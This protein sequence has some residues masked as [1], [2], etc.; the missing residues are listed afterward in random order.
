MSAFAVLIRFLAALLFIG[1]VAYRFFH[2][3]RAAEDE[4]RRA[5]IAKENTVTLGE[6]GESGS[7]VLGE[8]L[9]R[10]REA[11]ARRLAKG[12]SGPSPMPSCCSFRRRA[13]RS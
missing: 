10:A 3:R 9:A 11:E 13:L 6:G 1:F 7:Y 5:N 2:R 12:V 8:P 4:L